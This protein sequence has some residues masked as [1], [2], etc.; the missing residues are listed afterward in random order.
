[1][2]SAYPP[3]LI[4]DICELAQ[5]SAG[6]VIAYAVRT[7]ADEYKY[8]VRHDRQRLLPY[9]SN[10]SDPSSP[11]NK[12]PSQEPSFGGACTV[13][14]ALHDQCCHRGEPLWPGP[15]ANDDPVGYAIWRTIRDSVRSEPDPG[16]IENLLDI[17]R[18]QIAEPETPEFPLSQEAVSKDGQTPDD[19]HAAILDYL[20]KHGDRN[21]KV[22]R[23]EIAN[24]IRSSESAV[25]R[26]TAWQAYNTEWRAKYGSCRTRDGKGRRP[27]V[28]D[29]E[30]E[31]LVAEQTRDAKRRKVKPYERM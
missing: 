22:T 6:P 9:P 26:D 31:R 10:Q 3:E 7:W 2:E 21:E 4:D 5:G 14:A 18:A 23:K 17:V 8:A 20:T 24:A 1:M 12:E 30:V 11:Q 28:A 25:Q 29:G 15:P 13:L 27:T 19:R 16:Y